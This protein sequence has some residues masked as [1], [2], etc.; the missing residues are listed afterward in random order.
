METSQNNSVQPKMSLNKTHKK[1]KNYAEL[2]SKERLSLNSR[3]KSRMH[4]L[5]RAYDSLRMVIPHVHK[6]QKLSKIETLTLAK[7]YISSLTIELYK[8]KGKSLDSSQSTLQ[9][10]QMAQTAS[11][12]FI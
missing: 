8:I 6:N 2:S 3:E 10:N 11:Q 12:Y 4:S 7:N 9:K 5:N 1:H